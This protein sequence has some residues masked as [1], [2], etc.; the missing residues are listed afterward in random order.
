MSHT[1]KTKKG[2]K[3]REGSNLGGAGNNTCLYKGL[4]HALESGLGA[5][6]LLSLRSDSVVALATVVVRRG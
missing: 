2:G 5:F 6:R 3:K 4:N 1:R